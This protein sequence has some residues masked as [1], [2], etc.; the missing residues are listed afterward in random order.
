MRDPAAGAHLLTAAARRPHPGAEGCSGWAADR[1]DSW[2]GRIG[3]PEWRLPG[4]TELAVLGSGGFGEVVLARHGE[5]GTL[6][7]VK[8]LRLD[9][10]ADSG[11]AAM[12]RDEA[13][14]LASL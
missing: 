14:V 12:F 6:V 13:A 1:G 5:S 10:L 7:A 11:F 2:E 9:L 3:M 8:Y 4:Y